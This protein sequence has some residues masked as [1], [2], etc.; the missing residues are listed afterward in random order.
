MVRGKKG[1]E[2][3]L[4]AFKNVLDYSVTWLFC[5]LQ[6]GA[7]GQGPIVEHQPIIT[8]VEPE[9]SG[10]ANV[11]VPRFPDEVGER[12]EDIAEELLE[13]ISLVNMGS[14]RVRQDDDMD[15][16]LSRYQVPEFTAVSGEISKGVAELTHF[17]WHGLL[18]AHFVLKIYLAALKAAGNEW[19]ALTA[20]GFDERTY[21][22]LQD[23]K[24]TMA[25]EYSD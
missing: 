19:F 5:D 16:Y 8:T 4:W 17:R 15:A 14:P 22:I 25:W 9:V 23:G 7:S 1:F 12:N 13:W 11:V 20:T 2:R 6:A 18:P 10:F 3:V 21:T 24:H